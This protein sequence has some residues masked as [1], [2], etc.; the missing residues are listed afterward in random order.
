MQKSNKK[1]INK[2]DIR[3]EKKHSDDYYINVIVTISY[4][5]SKIVFYDHNHLFHRLYKYIFTKESGDLNK[6]CLAFLNF[7]IHLRSGKL[8]YRLSLFLLF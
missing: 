7:N 1:S 5:N 4:I 2:K 6:K 8:N 3:Q